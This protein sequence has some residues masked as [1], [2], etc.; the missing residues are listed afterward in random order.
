MD[1]LSSQLTDSNDLV[2][3]FLLYPVII[4]GWVTPVRPAGTAHGGIPMDLA[5]GE[6]GLEC[7]VDPW[8]ESF[9]ETV[10]VDDR[11]ELYIKHSASSVARQVDGKTIA[12]G[13]ENERVRLYVPKARLLEGVSEIYYQ[14]IRPSGNTE[15]SRELKVLY[16]RSAPGDPDGIR[17]TIP[18]EILKN[19]VG[20]DDAARGVEF[21]LEYFPR[22]AYDYISL[23][24]GTNGY[25][26]RELTPEDENSQIPL[27]QHLFTDTFQQNHDNP[28]TPIFYSVTDQLGN[29]TES[30]TQ[31]ID[32]HVDRVVLPAP[33]LSE[34][35]N[36][37]SDDPE[38]IDLS[39]VKGSLYVQFHAPSP[40]WAKG[41]SALVSY[42]CKPPTGS[43]VTHSGVITLEKTDYLPIFE[44]P[45]AKV[46]AGG[47]V[48]VSYEQV[49]VG[50]IAS[51]KP[52]EAKVIGEPPSPLELSFTNAPYEMSIGG[53]LKA[54]NLFLS[55]NGTPVPNTP[56]R[57]ILPE[58]FTYPDGA[59]G[60]RDFNTDTVGAVSVG[61]VKG[62]QR[63]GTFSLTASSNDAPTATAL[64]RVVATGP[65]GNITLGKPQRA[66]A[67]SPDGLRAYVGHVGSISVI[68]T[69][70]N[71]L[72]DTI[73]TFNTRFFAGIFVTPDGAKMYAASAGPHEVLVIDTALNT[74]LKR[75]P[76]QGTFGHVAMSSD[77]TL[78]VVHTNSSTH[79]AVK[80]IDTRLDQVIRTFPVGGFTAG[81]A[82]SPDG[83]RFYY[84][85]YRTA[86]S[87]STLVAIDLMTGRRIEAVTVAG[88]RGVVLLSPR[89]T[90]IFLPP[91]S[92]PG[93]PLL[94]M[95]AKPLGLR[96]TIHAVEPKSYLGTFSPDSSRLYL[97][98][99]DLSA[100]CQVYDT[101]SGALLN[102]FATGNH[103]ND[104]AL[105]PDG[106]LYVCNAS[107]DFVSVLRTD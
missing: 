80:V 18:E 77:G 10:A 92:Q 19:G 36:D 69:T 47:D 59:S 79:G 71:Q 74:V 35:L 12:R 3:L 97:C 60:E 55:D 6:K 8:A 17:L 72:I 83:Q 37:P 1:I 84:C 76:A 38:T 90:Q 64:V 96:S 105:T 25:V 44:V 42:T 51:S 34:V 67:I 65:V 43:V 22:R 54:I 75:I 13:E 99:Y 30:V 33:V 56:V 73:T 78:L 87:P 61:G 100:K 23:V 85:E 104:A 107:S 26:E 5:E 4:P 98:T 48:T 68:D 41:D 86:P 46:L 93:A 15:K 63:V 29:F 32:V 106:R 45:V 9:N 20:P 58:G 27:T 40:Q 57:L 24:L 88:Y 31:Y 50:V 52:A 94:K 89:G 102:T 7:L 82:I 14:V 62:P 103:S 53:Q 49:R 91:A 101:E 39:K 2:G 95:D 70:T 66:I 81:A 21:K 11:I 28:K 16:Y